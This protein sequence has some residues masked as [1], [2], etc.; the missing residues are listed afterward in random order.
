[1]PA[2]RLLLLR[3]FSAPRWLRVACRADVAVA[4]VVIGLM[5]G[6]SQPMMLE[7][8][9]ERPIFIREYATS[10]YG[11]VPYFI[12]KTLVELPITFIQCSLVFCVTYWIMDFNGG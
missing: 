9:L 8:P 5:F 3:W 7:F 12:S 1:M 4:A 10:H 2:H 6:A 11:V